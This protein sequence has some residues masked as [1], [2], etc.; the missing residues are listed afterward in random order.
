MRLLPPLCNIRNYCPT[1]EQFLE[2]GLWKLE[3]VIRMIFD[4]SE[5]YCIVY[6]FCH[7]HSNL[8]ATVGDI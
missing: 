2:M 6:M 7:P 3:E 5:P 8:R 4:L 1:G